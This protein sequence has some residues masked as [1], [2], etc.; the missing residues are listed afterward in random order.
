VIK[1]YCSHDRTNTSV[2]NV[3]KPYCT[4]QQG[5]MVP[6]YCKHLRNLFFSKWISARFYILIE[7]IQGVYI[8]PYCR[9]LANICVQGVLFVRGRYCNLH[10]S[11]LAWQ[12]KVPYKHTVM[13]WSAKSASYRTTSL[14]KDNMLSPPTWSKEK[15]C[16]AASTVYWRGAERGDPVTK[17][18]LEET[19]FHAFRN[20]KHSI[21]VSCLVVTT[22]ENVHD[23]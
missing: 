15:I 7:G 9:L 5:E 2:R 11:E 10:Y 13:Q 6:S 23:K 8:I 17:H 3:I 14:Q 4:L 20:I 16:C 1:P 18:S 21:L 12:T 19:K 22:Y